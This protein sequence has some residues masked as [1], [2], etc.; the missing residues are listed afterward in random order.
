MTLSR[1]Q[2]ACVILI[3]EFQRKKNERLPHSIAPGMETKLQHQQQQQQ[4]PSPPP[5][6]AL[7]TMVRSMCT[8]KHYEKRHRCVKPQQQRQSLRLFFLVDAPPAPMFSF[9][10]SQCHA[11]STRIFEKRIPVCFLRRHIWT[12]NSDESAIVYHHYVYVL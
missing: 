11:F 7:C 10:F 2:I 6:T 8:D 1:I 9:F 12:F 4:Q 5:Q 3:L